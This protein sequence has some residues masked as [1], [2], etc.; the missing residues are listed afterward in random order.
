MRN[1]RMKTLMYS[2]TINYEFPL[3]QR[4]HHLME[5]LSQRGWKV[6]WCNQYKEKNRLRQRVNENFEIYYDWDVCKR[7]NPEV[8]VYFSSWS[9]RYPDLDD[10]RAKI[11][12]YD[13]LDNFKQNSYYEPLM[14]ER[15]DVVLTTSKPLFDMRKQEHDNVYIC[16][17]ACFPEKGKQEYEIPEDLKEIKSN[18][19]PII[20]FSG[21]VAGHDPTG[22]CDIPLMEL[23]AEKFNMVIVGN[24]WGIK[25]PPKGSIF[26]GNKKYDELQAYY[27]HCDVNILPFKRCQVSDY[28]NP[29]KVYE[30][31]A[32]GKITVATDI[33]EARLFPGIVLISVNHEAFIANIEEA[34]KH[35]DDVDIINQ[36]HEIAEQNSWYKRVDVIDNAINQFCK[37]H[38]ISLI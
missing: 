12:V 11:V 9:M 30:A 1:L 4:P 16:R 13:S 2:N 10:I 20:L 8:D 14:L 29:I 3:K 32:H 25:E 6:I 21:A 19:K 7:R 24:L 35:K 5:I 36:C 31:M 27:H 37:N 15:A 34:L 22:W 17:N 26:L 28:S 23:I 33:P 38:N 18:N